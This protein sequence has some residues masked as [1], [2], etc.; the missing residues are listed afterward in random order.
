MAPGKDEVLGFVAEWYDPRPQLIKQFLLKYYSST[1]EAEMIDVKAKRLEKGICFKGFFYFFFYQSFFESC[2]SSAACGVRLSVFFFAC[3]HLSIT[4]DLLSD[5]TRVKTSFFPPPSLSN[6][7]PPSSSN[8]IVLSKHRCFLKRSKLP[9]SVVASDFNVGNPVLIYGRELKIIDYADPKTRD[10]LQPTSEKTTI[11]ITPALSASFGAVVSSCES[12]GMMVSS[13]K[14]LALSGAAAV[15][16][17]RS[18]GVSA[19]ELEASG[20]VSLAVSLTGPQAVEKAQSVLQK[21][22]NGVICATSQGMASGKCPRNVLVNV[23]IKSCCWLLFFVVLFLFLFSD[24]RRYHT[25][26]RSALLHLISPLTECSVLFPA[27]SCLPSF[28][29]ITRCA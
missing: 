24:G 8:H 12:S 6:L 13:I 17:S 27:R 28:L 4:H 25:Q 20:G 3:V 21:Y 26:T 9:S 16:A 23:K 10:T 22:G 14:T 29:T 19:E 5:S 11:F 2:F 1:H 7:P 15:S 18:L